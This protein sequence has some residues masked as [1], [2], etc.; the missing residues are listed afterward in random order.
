MRQRAAAV[1]DEV[2][3]E[4]TPTVTTPTVEPTVA[5]VTPEVLE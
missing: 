2:G 3:Q 1:T 5:A 4:D